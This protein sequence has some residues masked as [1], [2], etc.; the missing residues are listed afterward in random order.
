MRLPE[1]DEL[2]TLLREEREEPD[3]RFAEELDRWAAAGF[4][5]AERPGAPKQRRPRRCCSASPL[6]G[7]AR[8]PRAGA[9]CTVLVVIGIGVSQLETTGSDTDDSASVSGHRLSQGRRR[10]ARLGA[11][12]GR[13]RHRGGIRG[14]RAGRQAG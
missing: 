11:S 7:P 2:A 6:P 12:P 10:D 14:R 1:R 9:V 3:P 5:R 4:P 8:W 13:R